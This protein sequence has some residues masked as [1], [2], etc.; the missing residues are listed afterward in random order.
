MSTPTNTILVIFGITGDLARRKLL[1]ALR[2]ITREGLMPPGKIIGISRR[3]V[4]VDDLLAETFGATDDAAVLQLADR[5][6]MF[7]MDLALQHDYQRLRDEIA[8]T[9]I[10]M[11]G[12]PQVIFYL[13]VPPQASL[14]IITALGQAGLNDTKSVKLLIEKPFGVDLTSAQETIDAIAEYYDESQ[15]FRIDHYL[16]KE[17]AQNIV[18]FRSHNAMFRHLWNHTFIEKIEI[19]AAEHIGIEGRAGF[20]EQTGALRDVLQNHLLQLTALALMDIPDSFRPSDL[21]RLRLQALRAIQPVSPETF[22]CEV[23]RGQ[24]ASY[25]EE[26]NNPGTLTETFAMV[27][28]HSSAPAWEGV[29]IRLATGKHLAERTTEIRIFFKKTHDGEANTLVLH[30][31]PQE[32]ISIGLWAKKPGYDKQFERADLHFDYRQ[33]G[34]KPV[35]A[36]ERVLLDAFASDKSLFTSDAEV[37]ASWRILEPVQKRWEMHTDDLYLYEPGTA[38]TAL[39][40]A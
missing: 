1:P 9:A 2:T 37:L 16:A 7:A 21:P 32:G 25:A 13:S 12:N 34:G 26:V 29:P 5:M 19:I 33:P 15:L 22:A 6:S 10:A 14:P 20:Y 27:T 23:K 3:D 30:V 40:D 38:I 28:L 4:V 35:E 17:M 39:I 8:A 18:A 24:Y 36:Y 11:G 31:Q